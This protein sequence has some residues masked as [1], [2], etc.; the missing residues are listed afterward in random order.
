MRAN[1]GR[2]TLY[3]TSH[4]NG[5][6]ITENAGTV[7]VNR[8]ATHD[9]SSVRTQRPLTSAE[10]QCEAHAVGTRPEEPE[11]SVFAPRGAARSRNPSLAMGIQLHYSL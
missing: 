8:V 3:V 9:T 4:V 6:D 1:T 10:T 11:D 5:R 2:V 7:D